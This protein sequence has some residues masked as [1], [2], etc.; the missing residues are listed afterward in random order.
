M[1]VD[2]NALEVSLR[3]VQ[4][5]LH[6]DHEVAP[7]SS[8]LC[9]WLLNL[10]HDH[11]SLHQEKYVRVTMELE[12]P[13]RPIFNPTPSIVMMQRVLQWE[14]QKRFSH[15]KCQWILTKKFHFY[16]RKQK[17]IIE[18]RKAEKRMRKRSNTNKISKIALFGHIIFFCMSMFWCI[19]TSLSPHLVYT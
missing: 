12:V 17:K 5:C 13:T 18:T 14:R 7:C 11:F 10:S 3:W 15:C 19:V 1:I 9:D 16:K 2:L 6:H 4:G 8:K